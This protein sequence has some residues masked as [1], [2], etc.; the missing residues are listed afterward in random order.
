MRWH[1]IQQATVHSPPI[2]GR[3]FFLKAGVLFLVFYTLS[4][5]AFVSMSYVCMCV[6]VCGWVS[7]V[8]AEFSA[9]HSDSN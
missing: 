3:L 6:F 9:S 2:W 8:R 4:T 7:R 5:F 1:E